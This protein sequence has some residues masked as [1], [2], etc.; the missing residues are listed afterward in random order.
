MVK[1]IRNSL[2][3]KVHVLNLDNTYSLCSLHAKNLERIGEV[4]ISEVDCKRCLAKYE[5]H[6][7]RNDI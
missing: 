3:G 7:D 6:K 4:N 5:K 1:A 2:T